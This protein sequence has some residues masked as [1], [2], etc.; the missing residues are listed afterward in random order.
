MIAN[1]ITTLWDKTPSRAALPAP[2]QPADK[3]NLHKDAGVCVVS[4]KLTF[5]QHENCDAI[6]T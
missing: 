4:E 2:A 5:V 6:S 1:C 3:M